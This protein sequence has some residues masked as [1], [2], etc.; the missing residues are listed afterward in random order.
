MCLSK[1]LVL[2]RS[3]FWDSG[4]GYLQQK[5]TSYPDLF[6]IS[7]LLSYKLDLIQL[8]GFNGKKG[9][10]RTQNYSLSRVLQ[11]LV[12]GAIQKLNSKSRQQKFHQ[13]QVI[14]KE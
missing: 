7:G 14:P 11:F 10:E 5:D 12:C 13:I 1:Y 4:N 8:K 6:T 3:I 9:I 2:S